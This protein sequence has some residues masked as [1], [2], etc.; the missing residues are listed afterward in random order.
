MRRRHKL[1]ANV[2]F[3]PFF[4]AYPTFILQRCKVSAVFGGW[5]GDCL[6]FGGLSVVFCS[7]TRGTYLAF[8]VARA[9]SAGVSIAQKLWV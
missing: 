2:K 3:L 1:R 6:A 9:D 7:K 5:G 8:G 4:G